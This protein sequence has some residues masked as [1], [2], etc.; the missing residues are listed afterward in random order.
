MSCTQSETT[1]N[2]YFDGELDAVR[3]A[4]FERHLEGCGE[5]QTALDG[6]ESVRA[7]LR[8]GDLYEHASPALR[9]K[10]EK[11]LRLSRPPGWFWRLFSRPKVW[12]PAF[13]VLSLILAF[14]V[15]SVLL[16]SR[17]ESQESERITAELLDAHVRSLQPGHLADVQSNDQHNVKPWFDGKLDF[18]PPVSDYAA[19]GFTLVGGRLDVID[20]RNTAALVYSHGKHFINFFVW[21]YD[22]NESFQTSGTKR[23]YNWLV[24]QKG[25][26]R[27]CLVSDVEVSSLQQFKMLI[28]QRSSV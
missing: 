27:Y 25:N 21:P 1:L 20:N 16:S 5:C 23:G 18:I 24:W 13:A 2:G 7:R 6:M 28:Q 22:E 11:S 4:E 3:A 15:A 19:Q 17:E 12:A 10:I 26:M 8:Q 9:S 14:S